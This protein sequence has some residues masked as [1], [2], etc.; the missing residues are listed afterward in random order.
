MS[1]VCQVIERVY[2]LEPE[3]LLLLCTSIA[4]LFENVMMNYLLFFL[5]F[6]LS[7]VSSHG[8]STF[9]FRT[10]GQMATHSHTSLQN[11]YVG[12]I[13]NPAS[14]ISKNLSVGVSSEQR[15]GTDIFGAL[16]A[17]SMPMF[18]NQSVGLMVGSYGVEG[19]RENQLALAYSRPL[20]NKVDIG[21]QFNLHERRIILLPQQWSATANL[22]LLYEHDDL[23]RISFGVNSIFANQQRM[24]DAYLAVMHK[25]QPRFDV[26]TELNYDRINS[27]D[28]SIAGRYQLSAVFS[29]IMS[30]H[31]GNE[32]FGYGMEFHLLEHIV[33]TLGGVHH[34]I[35]GESFGLSAHYNVKSPK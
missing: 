12:L 34:P 23:T 9:S 16:I 20:S 32:R 26:I 7:V 35:L 8:Q 28:V 19:F 6:I 31:T 22:G 14:I 33:F 21:L 17:A 3:A 4:S 29:A 24:T 13:S 11:G 15:F 30:I 10:A 27:L 2:T 25:V 18:N 1:Y 5:L